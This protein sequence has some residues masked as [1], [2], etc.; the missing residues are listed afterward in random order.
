MTMTRTAT[1][2]EVAQAAGAAAL[3]ARL[4]VSA[5]GSVAIAAIVMIQGGCALFFVSNIL[6]SVFGLSFRP[7]PWAL[8]E[9]LEIGAALGLTMGTVLGALVLYRNLKGR[10]HAEERLRRVRAEFADHLSERFDRWGLTPAE[11]DVAIF[12]IKGL[13]TNEIAQLRQT[14]EGTV[15]AQTNAIYRKAGVNGRSQLLSLFIED[16]MDD[17]AV[18]A[19]TD[20]ARTA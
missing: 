20:L 6:L 14:S 11:S 9:Y 7:I 3:Y 8:R 19:R 12:A 15:K 4:M 17:A 2:T 10:K 5:S 13:R 1:T 16:M 18:T